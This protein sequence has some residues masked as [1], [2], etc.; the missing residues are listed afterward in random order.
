MR[1]PVIIAVLVILSPFGESE[2][3][4]AQ[5]GIIGP[6]KPVPYVNVREADVMWS[7]RIW[8]VI[9]LREKINLPL[10]YPVNEMTNRN[11]LFDVIRKG[12]VA[13]ELE[14]Y[15]PTPAVFTPGEE[16]KTKFS[17]VQAQN[18]FTREAGIMVQDTSTGELIPVTVM[19]TINSADIVQYW[20][21]EDWFFD[22]KRS[23]MDVR[24]LGIA[25]VIE[26]MDEQGEFKGYKILFWL[27]FPDCRNYFAKFRC[28]NPYNDAEQRTFDELFHKR[29]FASYIRQESNVYNRPIASYAQGMDALMESEKIK[30]DIFK[31]EQDMWHY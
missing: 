19:D 17:F 13:D 4:F 3:V 22:K 27:Y 28:Y 8:R 20:V 14:V 7:K 18:A 10:Y 11:S 15:D 29:M 9:D 1:T 12:V 31:F 26:T 5:V 24:I 25:P 23:V 6:P 16:F 21:K 2:K 30:E